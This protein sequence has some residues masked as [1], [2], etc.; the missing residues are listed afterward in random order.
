MDINRPRAKVPYCTVQ[1]VLLDDTR[2]GLD[3]LAIFANGGGGLGNCTIKCLISV[4]AY[5]PRF[6]K[7]CHGVCLIGDTVRNSI[8]GHMSVCTIIWKYYH[9]SKLNAVRS[10]YLLGCMLI[11][12]HL[13]DSCAIKI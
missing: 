12:G 7:I 2:A 3:K 5:A 10:L 8:M 4:Q 1:K 13:L 6:S 11:R 9:C